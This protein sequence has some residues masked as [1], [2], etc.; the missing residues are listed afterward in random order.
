MFKKI[1][2]PTINLPFSNLPFKKIPTKGG[3][4]GVVSLV[5]RTFSDCLLASIHN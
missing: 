3:G 1:N 5:L 2:Y 4:P